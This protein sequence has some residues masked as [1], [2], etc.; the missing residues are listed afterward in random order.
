MSKKQAEQSAAEVCLRTLGDFPNVAKD[1]YTIQVYR[2]GQVHIAT[3]K[4]KE[5]N[6]KYTYSL[7]QSIIA[8]LGHQFPHFCY[9]EVTK[10]EATS[11]KSLCYFEGKT[12]ESAECDSIIDAKCLA[13]AEA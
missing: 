8:S 6:S 12:F 13:A 11:T 3:R 4:L 9:K 5:S 1:K 2:G 7:L 10:G